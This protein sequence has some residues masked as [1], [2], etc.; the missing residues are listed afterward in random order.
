MAMQTLYAC[1]IVLW[2]SNKLSEREE[3]ESE[4]LSTSN[5][6]WA[7]K[8]YATA[9]DALKTNHMR[10]YF[11]AKLEQESEREEKIE[12]KQFVFKQCRCRRHQHYHGSLWHKYGIHSF[13]FAMFF[14]IV[15][16][17][18]PGSIIVLF[19]LKQV[20]S[21][22]DMLR[23]VSD[24]I[25]FQHHYYRKGERFGAAFKKVVQYR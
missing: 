23:Y 22:S 17:I 4:K 1:F 16:L 10:P 5:V 13:W 3:R 12:R 24:P 19:P 15:F 18:I 7:E 2:C 8:C 20:G 21:S 9:T 11:T 25:R 6:S 14:F